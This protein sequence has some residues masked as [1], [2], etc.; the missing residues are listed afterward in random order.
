[1]SGLSLGII[2]TVGLA[3]AIEAADTC[4]KSAN[5]VL[6]GYELTKGGGMA[7]VKI[8]GDV[9]AVNAAVSAAKTAVAKITSV[10]SSRVIARPSDEIEIL[11]RNKDTVGYE[12][13]TCNVCGDPKCNRKKGDLRSMCI[14]YKKQK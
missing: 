14:H 9:G 10:Y 11:I 13:I 7:V 8:E 3:A 5:V 4:L 6:I 1:M 2:E 12:E